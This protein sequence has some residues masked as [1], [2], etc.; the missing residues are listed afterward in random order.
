FAGNQIEKLID[1]EVSKQTRE[2]ELQLE[3]SGGMERRRRLTE[4]DIR[5]ISPVGRDGIAVK[6]AQ[7]AAFHGLGLDVEVDLDRENRF[8]ENGARY[9]VVA[10]AG[11]EIKDAVE[12]G[13][14]TEE[15][16]RIKT[17]DA[18]IRRDLA[19]VAEAWEGAIPKCMTSV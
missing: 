17:R 5:K 15:G 7:L 3:Y 2:R 6:L 14:L 13:R 19:E 16:F 12:I 9:I 18:E 4:G 1:N 10:D 11:K 8:A